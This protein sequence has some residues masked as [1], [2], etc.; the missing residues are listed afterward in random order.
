MPKKLQP[1]K[2]YFQSQGR[3]RHLSE[4]EIKM[5]QG[6]VNKEYGKLLNKVECLE[7]WD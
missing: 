4:D 1:I 7:A 2:N 5:I 6:R 3:Y